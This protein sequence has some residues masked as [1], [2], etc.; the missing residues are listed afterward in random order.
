MIKESQLSVMMEKLNNDIQRGVGRYMFKLRDGIVN[1][2]TS[3]TYYDFY[4]SDFVVNPIMNGM[5]MSM[6]MQ[7]KVFYLL[8]NIRE[9]KKYYK[10]NKNISSVKNIELLQD[11]QNIVMLPQY[12]EIIDMTPRKKIIRCKTKEQLNELINPTVLSYFS[13]K[14]STIKYNIN[15]INIELSEL[16]NIPELAHLDL[17]EVHDRYLLDL[18]NDKATAICLNYGGEHMNYLEEIKVGRT[19]YYRVKDDSLVNGI[20]NEYEEGYKVMKELSMNLI[21]G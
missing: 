4:D 19:K 21:V 10:A 5:P 17:C 1:Y 6:D 3:V 11:I 8:D 12:T 13:D 15:V 2:Y 7:T 18:E 9:I 16:L 20:I 14:G